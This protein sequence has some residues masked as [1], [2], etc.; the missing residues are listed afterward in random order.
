MLFELLFLAGIKVTLADLA[1]TL[2]HCV[3][4]EQTHF[5]SLLQKSVSVQYRSK[6]ISQLA[7][8][9]SDTAAIQGPRLDRCSVTEPPGL[10]TAL[11][12]APR[13]HL[14]FSGYHDH[15]YSL[16]GLFVYPPKKF[17][18]CLIEKNA[19]ST[20]IET[21]FQQLLREDDFSPW[22]E[23]VLQS[24]GWIGTDY[25]VSAISQSKF[26]EQGID[27][28]F[29][30]PT[31]TRAVFVRE[32]LERFASAFLNKCI[33]TDLYYCPVNSTVFRDVVEWA[34]HADLTSA[35]GHFLPQAFHCDLQNRISQYNVIALMK[36]D[37]FSHNM[38]CVLAKS[39]LNKYIWDA[40]RHE[41]RRNTSLNTTT[42][43]QKL[44][45]PAAALELIDRLHYDYDLFGFS[46]V[47]D[48]VAGA[49]GEWFDKDPTPELSLMQGDSH[50]KRDGERRLDRDTDD[51]VELVFR[52]GYVP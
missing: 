9:E 42:I 43:L 51:L 15:D 35:D 23:E 39:G 14:S 25:N 45:T 48:W 40:P 49:T 5:V 8:I 30:D 47:P 24:H 3:H 31:A 1:D 46:K 17:A 20:W 27:K 52:A 16:Q 18:F 2:G 37:T 50:L 36:E 44:F 32:P 10:N 34:M 28:I 7:S 19:C 38:N 33:D 12:L 11:A 6:A 41:N 4:E 13:E 26:G 21:V 22:L 29:Q